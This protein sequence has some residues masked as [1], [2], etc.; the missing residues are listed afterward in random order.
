[1]GHKDEPDPTRTVERPGRD[2]RRTG[3][4]EL[5]SALCGVAVGVLPVSCAGVLLL[6]DE[7]PVP[8]AASGPLAEHVMELQAG[9]GEGPSVLAART[10]A[11]VL[12][13]D[14]TTG[15]DTD[16]WPVF[17]PLARAA[18]VRALYA[19]PLGCGETCVGTLDL[20]SD[21]PAELTARDLRTARLLAEVVTV[22]L[23]TLRYDENDAGQGV[24]W[25]GEL[26]AGHDTV[27][28]AVGL[29]MAR[30]RI[31]ADEALARLRAFAFARGRTLP[32]AARDIVAHRAR[33][34]PD[35]AL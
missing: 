14:L 7:M 21:T 3:P 23:T 12:A 4:D 13:G 27:H 10:G 25:L 8:M 30:L 24:V 1:M 19:M 18:G 26:A 6:G 20:C 11:P 29:I 17:A 22:A 33:F 16:R 35:L 2:M 15:Q 31:A 28:Q 34:E 9:L 32:E 5:T